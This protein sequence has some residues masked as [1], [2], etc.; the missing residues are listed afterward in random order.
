MVHR[1][2]LV[3]VIMGIVFI[4]T[5]AAVSA[6][7]IDT[8]AAED[9]PV[10]VAQSVRHG[11]HEISNNQHKKGMSKSSGGMKG[12]MT[13][14]SRHGGQSYAHMIATHADELELSDAQLGRIVRLH[15][16]HA[17]EHTQFKKKIRKSMMHF[18]HASMKA[19]TDDATLR[20]LGND[21]VEAF[22]AMLEEHIR[23]RN[24]VHAI[25]TA[26]QREQL[27]TMKMNHGMHSGGHGGHKGHGKHS[28]KHSQR[29][30]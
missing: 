1:E 11:G 23:S 12:H 2:I 20:K 3:P 26:E 4:F 5:S 7:A 29:Y 6:S 14:R 18:H 16:K 30:Y 21:H 24:V 8:S 22:K 9:K 25:L 27:K 10:I 15:M 28:S 13:G 19:G 17:Q